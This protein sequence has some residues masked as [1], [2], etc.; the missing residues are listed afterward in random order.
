[1][2]VETAAGRIRGEAHGEVAAFRGIPYAAAARFEPPR[3]AGPWPGVLN[4]TAPGPAA[5]QPASRL[6]RV[7][8]A[9]A[10]EQSED[11]LFLNVW[12]PTA[13]VAGG[14]PVLVFLHG[15]GYSS[16]SGGLDW[17]D[18]GVLAERGDIVVVTVNYRLGALGFLYLPGLSEGNLGLRDQLSALRWVQEN[19]TAFG[20]DPRAV[21][22]AGQ[23]AGAFSILALLSGTAA[24]GL[25]QRAILQ[26]APAGM[27]PQTPARAT[28]VGTLLLDALGLRPDRA[29][30]LRDVPVAELLAAQ[31]RVAG[32]TSRLLDPTP[33]FHLVADGEL[34]AADLVAAA[35]EAGTGGVEVIIGT[36]R[37]EAS[38]FLAL[39][40]RVAALGPDEL[41]LAA[42]AWFGDPARAFAPGRTPAESAA[43]LS[44]AHMF[45]EPALRLAELF[46]GHGDPVWVY[47]FDWQPAGSPYGACHC[48][49]LPFVFGDPAAWRDAPMLG[50]EQPARLVAQ[51][52]R[53]WAGFVR[54]GDPGWPR[55]ERGEPVVRRFTGVPGLG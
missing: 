52:Q 50:G 33:P 53:A 40:D 43:E 28:E 26:S 12:T 21:T 8:G 14:R 9:R 10:M 39:N 45:S 34:V 22:V 11:C 30:N 3:P 16:G 24:R 5:P 32:K 42:T 29:G 2:I 36:T 1:M 48:I 4:A 44:T 41:A 49:E 18:G 6:E 19:I 35:G 54:R 15:G 23:S 38:A 31:G 25:F 20:G 17:Y 51:V 27:V 13:P 7:M 55:Y 37:D 47:R 46:A